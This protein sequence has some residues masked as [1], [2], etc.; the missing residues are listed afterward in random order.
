MTA[1][2]PRIGRY[3]NAYGVANWHR[4]PPAGTGT[5]SLLLP[6]PDRGVAQARLYARGGEDTAVLIMHPRG[7]F[8]HHY[9]V[10]GLVEAGYAVMC[11]ASRWLNNDAMLVHE[12]LLL[13][14][15]ECVKALRARY[16]RVVL[17]GNSG[18]GSLMT[19]YSAQAAAPED[20]RLTDTAAGDPL[21]LGDFDLPQADALVYVGA[22]VGEGHF[23]MGAIDPSVTDDADAL[24][25][26]PDLDIYDPRNGFAPPPKET[27]YE[28]EFLARYRQAQ[29]DRV[30]RLDEQAR[31]LV[32]VRREAKARF[33]ETGAA[34]DRR[35]SIATRFLVVYRT[36]ADP[37]Y[38]DLSLDPSDRDYGSLWGGRP[39]LINYGAVGFGR[40]VSPEAWLSTWSGLSSRADIARTGPQV[41]LPAL[42]VGYRADN[43]IFP[44]ET[45]LIASSLAGPVTRHDVDGDHYGFPAAKG[46]EQAA[47]VVAGWLRTH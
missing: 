13:D 37:R 47:A 30:A 21:R 43:G 29:R 10:P 14:V 18:G 9:L 23:L 35:A 16:D 1:G 25:C 34:A 19:F 3:A 8:F 26:D 36:D 7:D 44:S 11:G 2:K 40:V 46:R 12:R 15:A 17:C 33:A 24:S 45:D 22:H 39:D 41:A 38:V 31:E 32:R 28:P 27:R 5:E 42:V 20:E 4:E 6:T